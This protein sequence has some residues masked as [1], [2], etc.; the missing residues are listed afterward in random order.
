MDDLI[1]R[2]AVL[3]LLHALPP[4]DAITKAM[5]IQNVKYMSAAQPEKRTEERTEKHACDCISRQAAIEAI[6]EDKIDLT[7]TNVVAV[8]KATGDFEKVETQVMTCDRHIEIL[9]DLPSAQLK[10]YREGYQAGFK[11]AQ[12]ERKRGKRSIKD[13]PGTGWY[14]V[15]CSECGED[16]T[17][18]AP[19]IGFYPNAKVTWDYCPNCGADM[20]EVSE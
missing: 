16:V 13:N 17:S 5:L 14:R 11:D 9:K 7:N 3:N 20:R 6:K 10:S 15:T 19:C 1:S 18:T 12:S 4:E 2:Q 8:F